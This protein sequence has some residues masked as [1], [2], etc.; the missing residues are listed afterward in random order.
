M[1][2]GPVENSNISTYT[3]QFS[4]DFAID[5]GFGTMCPNG[6]AR[7]DVNVPL[8]IVSERRNAIGRKVQAIGLGVFYAYARMDIASVENPN[9]WTT[10]QQ[11]S[12]FSITKV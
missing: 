4:L 8:N 1:N 10:P 5:E 7:C 12:L 6:V 3:A 2:I 11:F 9:I